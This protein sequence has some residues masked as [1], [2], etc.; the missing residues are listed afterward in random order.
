MKKKYELSEETINIDGSILYKIRALGDFVDKGYNLGGYIES[1]ENLSHEGDC[2]ISDD[3]M[4]YEN[5]QISN[6]AYVGGRAQVFGSVQ[7]FSG[8]RVLQDARVSG[9][10]WV[11]GNAQVC[12]DAW[13]CK[14]GYIHIGSSAKIDH[15]VWTQCIPLNGKYYVTSSPT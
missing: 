2:W 5:A 9:G 12:G 11:S 1:E 14:D 6:D 8:A 3:A 13:I 4:I 15:G 7:V 10:A